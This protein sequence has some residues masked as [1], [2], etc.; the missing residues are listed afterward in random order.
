MCPFSFPMAGDSALWEQLQDCLPLD[1][2]S[3]TDVDVFLEKSFYM[4][5][6]APGLWRTAAIVMEMVSSRLKPSMTS[7]ALPH[8]RE[9]TT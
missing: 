3:Q 8:Q 6:Q 2:I 4:Q 1:P 5:D 9:K 7:P